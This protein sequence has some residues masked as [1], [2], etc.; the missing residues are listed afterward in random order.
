MLE[1]RCTH[2]EF[3]KTAMHNESAL[4]R[5]CMGTDVYRTAWGKLHAEFR[6]LY[7][8]VQLLKFYF[9]K[10]QWFSAHH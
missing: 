3:D 8:F 4:T 7:R 2:K 1:T 5:G 10:I 9:Q 6:I